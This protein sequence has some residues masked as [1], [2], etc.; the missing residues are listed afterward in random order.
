M[1]CAK[2]APPPGGPVDNLPPKILEVTPPSGAV[3]V[4]RDARVHFHFSE[5][6]DRRS[7][8]DAI[9]VTPNPGG[10]LEFDWN[11]A[12]LEIKFP[13]SLRSNATYVVTLGT[14][15]RDL[16]NNRLEQSLSVAFSTGDSIASGEIS[17]RIYGEK[18]QG[19]LIGAY[20]VEE[21]RQPDPSRDLADYTTQS[22]KSGE[23]EF[24]YLVNGLYRL[25]AMDD[26]YGNRLYDRGEDAIAVASRDVQLDGAQARVEDINL[27]MALEDTLRPTLSSVVATDNRHLEWRFEEPAAPKDDDWLPRL[28][29]LPTENGP[30]A[31]VL[32]ASAP[33]PLNPQTVHSF[34]APQSPGSYRAVAD[35]L[36]DLSGLLLDSLAREVEFVG[37]SQSDT[38]RPRLA[39]LL[40]ADSTR[41]VALDA[42]VEATFSELMRMDSTHTFLVVRDSAGV[43]VEGTGK[44]KNHFQFEF[45]PAAGWGSRAKYAI[46][47]LPDSGFDLSGLALFDTT[48]RRIFWTVNADT[49]SS[50]GGT[51]S[52]DAPA[53]TGPLRMSAIQIG[54][55]TIYETV[56]PAPGPY[57]FSGVL[58][59][60]YQLSVYRDANNNGRY[61]FGKPMPFLPA[62][63]F[64]VAPDSIKVR[65]RWPNEGNEVRLP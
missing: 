52:D 49:L 38:L 34:T 56:I 61:D 65:A 40:P 46:D 32:L 18:V 2:Q 35:E 54:G 62:E 55:K 12:A 45:K 3:R 57:E 8:A 64:M 24:R 60:V 9:F 13:D 15:L 26:K 51:V 5:K 4:P 10:D 47:V 28:R 43:V 48:R 41:N 53:A 36:F 19:L 39:R 63:R 7:L 31:F 11:G 22:G 27:R 6:I 25:C 44:W 50:I 17:G 21:N 20:L 37:S 14:G 1:A 29:I 16:R 30:A 58:P 33:H 23:F 42:P 59:G